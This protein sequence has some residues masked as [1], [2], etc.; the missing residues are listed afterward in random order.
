MK[1]NPYYQ[2]EQADESPT[3]VTHRVMVLDSEGR[4]AIIPAD[5]YYRHL[6]HRHMFS[7]V[8]RLDTGNVVQPAADHFYF[9]QT[10]NVPTA[11]PLKANTRFGV[12][13]Y[14]DTA[15]VWKIGL[16]A[17]N[18]FCVPCKEAMVNYV[19]VGSSRPNSIVEI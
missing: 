18:G 6:M 8:K 17:A 2:W 9:P 19:V 15:L 7:G 1:S 3:L 10:M 12:W 5:S 14:G 16:H 4:A 11:V 13:M